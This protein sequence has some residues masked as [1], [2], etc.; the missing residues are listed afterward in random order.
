MSW[1]VPSERW[2]RLGA[3][4]LNEAERWRGLRMHSSTVGAPRAGWGWG[5]LWERRKFYTSRPEAADN[6]LPAKHWAVSEVCSPFF[7]P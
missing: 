4:C 6:T 3:I 1:G 5:L 2:Q 7:V